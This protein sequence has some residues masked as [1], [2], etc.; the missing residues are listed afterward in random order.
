MPRRARRHLTALGGRAVMRLLEPPGIAS[1][2]APPGSVRSPPPRDRRARDG[3]CVAALC[4]RFG[5]DVLTL[6]ASLSYALHLGTLSSV[7]SP[8]T[9][10]K[11]WLLEIAG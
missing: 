4:A 2:S 3:W 1:G 7:H 6:A 10:I 5:P 9:T 11:D 8:E